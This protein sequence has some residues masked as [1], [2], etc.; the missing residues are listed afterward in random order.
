MFVKMVRFVGWL[1]WIGVAIGLIGGLFFPPEPC[2]GTENIQMAIQVAGNATA[3]IAGNA[4]I[5]GRL[6]INVSSVGQQINTNI[7]QRS[8]E[9]IALQRQIA[10]DTSYIANVV[11]AVRGQR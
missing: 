7:C 5:F 11:R 4:W 6:F 2:C 8:Q 10:K 1:F 9:R 3:G